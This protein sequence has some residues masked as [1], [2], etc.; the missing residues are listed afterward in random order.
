[1]AEETTTDTASGN[2]HEQV[3]ATTTGTEATSVDEVDWKSKFEAQQKVNRDLEAK[4][5]GLYAYK[6]KSSELEAELSKYKGTEQEYEESKKAQA[7]K[8][9]LLQ[10]ANERIVKAEVRACAAGKLSDPSDALRFIDLSK[11]SVS[12]D[13]EVDAD[14]ISS[15]IGELIASKPYLGAQGSTGNG[16]GITPPSGRRDGDRPVQLTRADLKGMSPAEIVKAQA[17]GLLADLLKSN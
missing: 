5:K 11:F 12:E 9:S 8:D 3:T 14:A 15:A 1:M 10:Q 7:L 13:G 16:V 4:N 2:E 17:D 6:D